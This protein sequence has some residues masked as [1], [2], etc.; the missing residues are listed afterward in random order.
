MS[1]VKKTIT[2]AKAESIEVDYARIAEMI[3]QALPP[4]IPAAPKSQLSQFLTG[5][6]ALILTVVLAAVSYI[7]GLGAQGDRIANIDNN[8][9]TLKG[10]MVTKD[11]LG[12][13]LSDLKT[14]QD[15]TTS[16]IKDMSDRLS[17]L[18]SRAMNGNRQ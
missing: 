3:N 2:V 18:E 4:S 14:S 17:R 5:Y 9:S 16:N 15:A 6:G 13:K 12:A 7:F 1:P 8:L 10:S 11:E